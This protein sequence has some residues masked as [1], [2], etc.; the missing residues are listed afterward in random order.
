[1]IAYKGFHRDLT[2]TM[3]RGV[4]QFHEGETVRE[5]A[6]KCAR[7]GFHCAEDPL[8]CFSYYPPGGGNRYFQVEAGGSLDEDG[9]DSKIA[10]TELTLVRELTVRQMVALGMMYMVRC[11]MRKWERDNGCVTVQRDT[12][13]CGGAGAIA[14]ARGPEPRVKGG[15]GAILGLIREPRPGEIVD[16]KLFEVSGDVRP[17]VWYT[18]KDRE[19]K[20]VEADEA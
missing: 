7:S 14:I 8:D 11:P 2:C 9:R 17:D 3:G 20:E 5:D 6:S 4:F 16:A 1:M 15:A 19:L 12:A 10:C 18:L 13:V